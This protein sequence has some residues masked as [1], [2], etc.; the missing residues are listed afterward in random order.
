MWATSLCCY[1][2]HPIFSYDKYHLK[3]TPQ[4]ALSTKGLKRFSI[5]RLSCFPC[6]QHRVERID[7]RL[8]IR[9][10][11]RKEWLQHIWSIVL[12]SKW[13]YEKIQWGYD[14]PCTTVT[15]ILNFAFV[16]YPFDIPDL[17]NYSRIDLRSSVCYEK[18]QAEKLY[19]P[20]S[21]ID[22]SVLLTADWG[23]CF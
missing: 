11:D 17:Y 5:S 1:S 23:T 14:T 15:H 22:I 8:K 7:I 9:V 20:C 16:L 12:T 10:W 21:K 3:H 6:F 19:I 18:K 2:V 4:C 13:K